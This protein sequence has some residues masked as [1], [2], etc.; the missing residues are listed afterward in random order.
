MVVSTG[1]AILG[2]A[3]IGGGAALIGG[4]QA[5]RASREAAEVQAESTDTAI[6]EQ[7]R[8]ADIAQENLAPFL[9][10]SVAANDALSRLFNLQTP[11][12]TAAPPI[13]P[14]PAAIPTARNIETITPTRNLGRR[15]GGGV[16]FQGGN[17]FSTEGDIAEDRINNF[18]NGGRRVNIG[19]APNQAIRNLGVIDTPIAGGPIGT[20]VSPGGAT[21]ATAAPTGAP[22]GPATGLDVFQESPGFQFRQEQGEQAINRANAARGRFFSGAAIE[23]L[24]EFN[25]GLASS[26]FNNF[27]NRLNALRTGG[28]AAATSA[29]AA[30]SASSGNIA[31][32]IQT[33][34]ANRASGIVGAANARN[35]GLAGVAGAVTGGIN[36]ALLLNRGTPSTANVDFAPLSPIQNPALNFVGG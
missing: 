26:E 4:G 15:G 21:A 34:G 14:D 32:L 1:A 24:A 12:A 11:T 25:S 18:A 29:T 31:N 9:A 19:G 10:T 8:Q 33:G 20:E 22:D 27:F 30:G 5:A 13:T 3:V 35:Q 7:R 16:R 23:N 17:Q 2:A 36:N 28:S 6:V